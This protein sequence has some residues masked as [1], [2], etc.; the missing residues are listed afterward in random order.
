MAKKQIK[1][2][3]T[4]KQII[5]LVE[6][7]IISYVF[8][9]NHE[10]MPNEL[11]QYFLN[12]TGINNI[13]DYSCLRDKRI[14]S[15]IDWNKVPKNKILRLITRDTSL[16][17]EINFDLHLFT[18][19]ELEIF[20]KFNPEYISKL[21]IDFE[22]IT[23]KECIIILGIDQNAHYYI[24][25]NK[26][27]F[28]RL[29]IQTLVKKFAQNEDIINALDFNSMD[30]FIQKNL[31]K[32]TGDKYL[33]D[34]NLE[35]FTVLDWLDLI[36]SKPTLFKYCNL[37]LFVKGDCYYLTKLAQLSNEKIIYELIEK[38]KNNLSA[39]GW[40]N[41]LIL[42]FKKYSPICNW[43]ILKNGNYKIL[44]KS[45]PDIENYRLV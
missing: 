37:D 31:L 22:N 29:D 13:D 40:Q 32:K 26:I 43:A 33:G 4:Y 34:L 41:L 19:T 16:I 18:I 20:L 8:K 38:N 11:F 42:D 44:K 30:N 2:D 45:I 7:G 25:F 14:R 23:P 27:Q 3:F 9:N 17:D 35:K 39:L 36:Q 12:N 15:L 1:K 24:N 10:S 5:E 6:N 28:S 21:N